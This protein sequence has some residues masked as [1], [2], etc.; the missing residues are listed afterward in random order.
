MSEPTR[1]AT[2][3]EAVLLRPAMYTLGG[4]YEETIAFLE[5]Y[6][7][8]VARGAPHAD[9]IREWEDF[10]E[11]LASRLSVPR[12]EVFSTLRGR[13]S[14][15]VAALSA[16]LGELVEYQSKWTDGKAR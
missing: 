11:W 13:H 6:H 12:S 1:H 14:S 16:L 8:G 9:P 15:G 4:S 2:F 3:P 7:S 10:C 5:G